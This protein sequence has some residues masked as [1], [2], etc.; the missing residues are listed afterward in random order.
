M[1]VKVLQAALMG[2]SVNAAGRDPSRLEQAIGS[3]LIQGV[4][5][6]VISGWNVRNGLKARELNRQ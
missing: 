6:A 3:A 5:H 4:F 1:T 2:W